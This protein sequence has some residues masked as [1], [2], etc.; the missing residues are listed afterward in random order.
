MVKDV[1]MHPPAEVVNR[2]VRAGI[3]PRSQV[4]IVFS[5]PLQNDEQHRVIA[6]A[7]AD[8]LGGNLQRTL[9][10]DLGGTYGVSVEPNYQKRPT[11]EYRIAINFACDPQRV[12]DL[13]AAAFRVIDTFKAVGPS[14]SQVADARQ[15]LTRDL[16]VNSRDNQYLLNRLLFKY[17]YGENIADVFNMQPFYEQV[18]TAAIRDA[19]RMYL[20]TNR[21]VKVT[22][23][24]VT[25]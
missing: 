12:N 14:Q 9:R 6:N 24:P 13:V 8:T 23:M 3:E 21:Y 7:M 10:E 19:A 17:E 11:Q 22:L 5:G 4:S 25:N 15:G 16:E 2:E 18:T 20:N 1:G